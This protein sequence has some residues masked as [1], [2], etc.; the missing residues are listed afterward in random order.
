MSTVLIIRSS[1]VSD[2][3]DEEDTEID[4]TEEFMEK[5]NEFLKA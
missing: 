2:E 3:K 1:F 4:D 5:Y